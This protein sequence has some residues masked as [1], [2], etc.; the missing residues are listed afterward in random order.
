LT[1]P[2][3]DHFRPAPCPL[4]NQDE[5]TAHGIECGYLTAPENRSAPTGSS[6]ELAVAL[7]HGT[8][9][10][11]APDPVLFLAGGPGGSALLGIGTWAG[12]TLR[13]THDVI[14]FD[15]RG[16]GYSHPSLAC[17]E[18]L[19]P[20]GERE[21]K[22]DYI[23]AHLRQAGLCRDRL[24]TEGVDLSAYNTNENAADV[25][26]LRRV[27]GIAR[28]NLYGISYGTRLALEVMRDYPAGVRSVVLD[29]AYPPQVIPLQEAGASAD[30][31]FEALVAACAAEPSCASAYPGLGIG[32]AEAIARFDR[33]FR[34]LN[35]DVPGHTISHAIFAWL[36]DTQQIELLPALVHAAETGNAAV[37]FQ[38][39]EPT[40]L[41]AES[42]SDGMFLSVEC[43]ERAAFAD[44]ALIAA[45]IAAH[46]RFGSYL[47]RDW[48]PAAC[49]EWGAGIADAA[50][51]APVRSSI[52]TLVFAGELDPVTPPEYGELAASTLDH[53]TLLRIPGAGH[54]VT[55]IHCP[56]DMRDAFFAEPAAPPD[57]T[58][59]A[60]MYGQRDRFYTDIVL[61]T[62]LPRI[63]QEFSL[64]GPTIGR[65][66]LAGFVALTFVISLVVWPTRVAVAGLRRLRRRSELVTAA[67]TAPIDDEPPLLPEHPRPTFRL[68][69]LARVVALVAIGLDIVVVAGIASGLSH[70][71]ANTILRNLGLLRADAWVLGVATIGGYVAI[72]LVVVAVIAIVLRAGSRTARILLT[73]VAIAALIFSGTLL[74]YGVI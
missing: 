12:T 27:L 56:S 18:L 22:D 44:P 25:E 54:G 35:F 66:M 39:M 53:A 17:P 28:W 33:D 13:A 16:T 26:D 45:D 24:V 60:T 11:V 38:A 67:A 1:L 5:L 55:L 32:L 23:A 21:S 6:V 10:S 41:T 43:S 72:A 4:G 73:L 62:G 61:N 14:L 19:Y 40:L 29:S 34:N 31:A 74:Y 71:P 65:W 59:L 50:D 8:G 7:L 37:Y 52:P 48:H 46:P 49:A 20:A 69:R 58:C 51:V 57:T 63:L 64:N 47:E 2:S 68:V 70:I 3:N 42:R 36:Y 30:R 9:L 15:Q